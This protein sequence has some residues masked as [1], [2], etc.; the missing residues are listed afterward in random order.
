[1]KT[2]LFII[3]LSFSF[4]TVSLSR[5]AIRIGT[6]YSRRQSEYLDQDWKKVYISILDMG[7]DIL[8]LG[9]YWDRIEKEEGIYNFESLD[10]QIEEAKKKNIPVILT[11]GMK[12][13]RWPEYYIPEW[14]LKR[15]RLRYGQDVSESDY[16]REKTI[17]FIRETVNR[18]KDESIICCWQVE[19]EPFDRVGP[20]RWWIG[21]AFLGEEIDVVRTIDRAERPVMINAATYPNRLLR[22]IAGITAPVDAIGEAIKQCDILGLNIYPTVGHK[23]WWMELYFRTNTVQRIQCFSEIVKTARFN[24]K[25]VWITELQA[26]PWEPGQLVHTDKGEP[27]TTQPSAIEES[28]DEIRS[29]GI[30]VILL[31][32]AEY[33]H[34]RDAHHADGAWLDGIRGLLR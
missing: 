10:W 16:V 31:W 5:E 19:N 1:M 18:Y 20:R 22:F 29:L 4:Q 34:F 15:A 23:L 3:I 9:A 28:F 17:A 30:D 2:I 21:P 14:C 13:P 12:A 6:T 8:R 7:F 32:G 26:E 33:W 11:V 27:L 25:K 24:K